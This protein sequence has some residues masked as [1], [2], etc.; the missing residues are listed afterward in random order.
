M[1]QFTPD[2]LRAAIEQFNQLEAE[3]H[4]RERSLEA[5]KARSDLIRF[6]ELTM[7]VPDDPFDWRKSRY[8]AMKHHRAIAAALEEVEKGHWLRVI[9]NAPPRHGKSELAD[10]RFIP[11]FVGRDPY[12]SV[13]MGTYNEEFARDFG[14]EVR[15]VMQSPEYREIFPACELAHGSKASDRLRTTAGGQMVFVGRGGS[16]TGRG[17]DLLLIDDPIKDDKEAQSPTIRDQLW[18]WF[19][20]VAGTR[21]MTG[22]GR[23][24]IIQTR[25]HEDD[26]VGRLTDPLNPCYS[27]R[28]AG[29]WRVIDLPALALD[30]DP[31]GREKG[32]PLWPERF[33]KEYLESIRELDSAGFSALYQGRPSPEEG[34]FFKKDYI[35]TYQPG[36]LPTSLRYYAAS[37]HAVGTDET[38]DYTCIVIAGVDEDDN[39]W[40]VDAWWRR[41]ITTTVVDA[42]LQMMRQ[43]PIQ[44][45]W[46]ERGHISKSI[47]PFLRKRMLEE[48]EFCAIDEQTPV[49]DK[50]TRAQSIQGR[51]AM[52][53][54]VFPEKAPWFQQA[55]SEMLKFDAGTHDDFVD[56]IAHLGMGLAKQLKARSPLTLKSAPRPGTLGHLKWETRY[57]EQRQRMARSAAG[58]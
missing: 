48:K 30:D 43:Y 39:I 4:R 24:V 13:I 49:G 21:L 23:I 38:H 40:I 41:A 50:R 27:Q 37:D 7:P 44:M 42:M 28:E 20:R 29:K 34:D 47:G 46:A 19:T 12:R 1:R 57:R 36:Q 54:V 16:L 2:E 15:E 33:D 56:A 18:R 9:V 3:V 8:Q 17:A 35:R 53:K 6:T 14:G 55:K 22:A 32:E 45:W 31:L 10:R 58:F 25:W 52:G 5:G 26:L 11:Y 51:M